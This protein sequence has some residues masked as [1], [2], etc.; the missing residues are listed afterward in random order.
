MA[1]AEKF[2]KLKEKYNIVKTFKNEVNDVYGESINEIKKTMKY[3]EVVTIW[4]TKAVHRDKKDEDV[5]EYKGQ[6][7]SKKN[8]SLFENIINGTYKCLYFD[9]KHKCYK[10]DKVEIISS[11]TLNEPASGCSVCKQFII[12]L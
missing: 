1:M 3:K 6:Y 11:R 2:I 8:D 7:R 5:I 12:F 10:I 9:K 4:N